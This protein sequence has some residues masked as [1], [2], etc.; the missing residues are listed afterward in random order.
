MLVRST[1]GLTTWPRAAFAAVSDIPKSCSLD[2][3]RCPAPAGNLSLARKVVS[4]SRGTVKW[5]NQAKGFGFIQPDDGGADAFVHI[6]AVE[7]AGLPYLREGQKVEFELMRDRRGK[8]AADN[9][10]ALT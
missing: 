9:L 10:K 1:H 2:A 6:S 7:R 4:M 8:T 3:R 5:F